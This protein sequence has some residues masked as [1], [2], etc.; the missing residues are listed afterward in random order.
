MLAAAGI[1]GEGGT[2]LVR[3]QGLL[4]I[5]ARVFSIWLEDDDPGMA[6]TIEPWT[7]ACGAGNR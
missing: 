3:V 1:S 6:R 7:G 2:G 5:Y 4:S